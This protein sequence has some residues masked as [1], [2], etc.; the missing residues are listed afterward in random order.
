MKKYIVIVGQTSEQYQFQDLE[1]AIKCF[2]DF[3]EKNVKCS[4]MMQETRVLG[5]YLPYQSPCV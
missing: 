2:A 1:S 5:S 3:V 4:I